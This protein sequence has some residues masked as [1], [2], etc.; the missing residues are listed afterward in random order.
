MSNIIRNQGKVYIEGARRIA[1]DTG[2]MC[3]FASAFVS[4][5]ETLNEKI[6]YSFVM[7]VS[8]V[9][10]RTTIAPGEWDFG[11]Y[12]ILSVAEDPNEAVERAFRAAGYACKIYGPG[13]RE[14]N[15]AVITESIDRGVPV[16]AYNVVGPSN[17]VII[18]GYDEGGDVLLGW[19]TYQDIPDDHNI[20]H[21]TTGYFRKPGW[22]DNIP[23]FITIG[24]KRD[25]PPLRETYLDS[26]KWAVHLLRTPYMGKKAT[27]LEGL[28]VWAQEMTDD[29]QFPEND[30]DLV[31]WRYVSVAINMTMLRDHTQ[32]VP[33][34]QQMLEDVPEF[35]PEVSQA[36][37]CYREV[38][39]IRD[40]MDGI[41]GDGFSEAAMKAIHDPEAR[42]AYA[43]KIMLIR[44]AEAEA[45]G[46]FE[47]L[48]A[49]CG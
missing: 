5:L 27:G 21:D 39:L 47:A 20:P 41:I 49:R 1:W 31:G 14:K 17:C 28:K 42:R 6:P 10:F 8:G 4:A 36:L 19:S 9:A 23:G 43:E 18:T 46:H 15:T 38:S 13:D 34:L 32:A 35:N 44:E 33:Y 3:E 24:E 12:S 7:G 16:L 48:L 37:D 40:E 26:L 29:T 22:Y 2:E 45:A 25:R 11:N 30:P